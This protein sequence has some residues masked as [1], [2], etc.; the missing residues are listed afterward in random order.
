MANANSNIHVRPKLYTFLC[1]RTQQQ[2]SRRCLIRHISVPANSKTEV[3]NLH[4][5]TSQAFGSCNLVGGHH[6]I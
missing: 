6:A 2:L 1:V 5:G 4:A 3:R